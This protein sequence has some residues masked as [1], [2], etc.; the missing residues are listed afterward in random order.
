M[1]LRDWMKANRW[2]MNAMCKETGIA[3]Q[4]IK[5]ARDK[6]SDILL[7]TAMGIYE[8]TKGEV[9]YSEMLRENYEQKKRYDERKKNKHPLPTDSAI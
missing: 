5:T 8:F 7:K 3:R 1:Q 2:T 4:T 6:S 9:T